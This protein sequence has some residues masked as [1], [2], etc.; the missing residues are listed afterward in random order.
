MTKYSQ[1]EL[2]ELI[3]LVEEAEYT[4]D[5]LINTWARAAKVFL[6]EIDNL[7]SRLD[8]VIQN[9]LEQDL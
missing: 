5:L 9:R 8:N 1:R 7:K 6:V 2:I 4:D 3:K